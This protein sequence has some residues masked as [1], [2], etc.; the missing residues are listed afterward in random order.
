MQITTLPLG[1]MQANG[2]IVKA[3]GGTAAVVDPGDEAERLLRYLNGEE[4]RVTAVWL[5]HGHF[6]H[7][8]AAAAH[9]VFLPDR[10]SRCGGIAFGRPAEKSQ[11]R[12]FAR[13]AVA[14][15]GHPS[16]RRRHLF[17]R[18]G[19]RGGAAHTGTHKRELL[20]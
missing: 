4:L 14:D 10:R 15:G 13:A 2:Y 18:R 8:G 19:D 6:D 1:R 5:T 12:I 20:L 11:Q 3:D 16:C 9:G 7:I 17:L